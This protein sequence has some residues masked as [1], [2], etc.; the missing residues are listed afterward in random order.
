MSRT[1][2][3]SL[4]NS[5]RTSSL[6]GV[7]YRDKELGNAQRELEDKLKEGPTGKL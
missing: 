6:E 2:E 1:E 5:A 7:T 3:G 4:R